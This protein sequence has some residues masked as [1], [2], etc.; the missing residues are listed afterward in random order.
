[1]YQSLSVFKKEMKKHLK[2]YS[3]FLKGLQK[4]K[5]KG[6]TSKINSL[7]KEAYAKIDCGQ[8]ANCCKTMTPTYTKADV[9]RISAHVGMTEK[10]YWKKYLEK[11]E[12]KDI[13]NRKTPCHFL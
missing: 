11:D 7:H 8:C 2:V 4:R 1:M 3:T 9:K 6:I 5:V 10:E 13:V 12:H